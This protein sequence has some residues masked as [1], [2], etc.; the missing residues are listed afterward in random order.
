MYLG[1]YKTTSPTIQRTQ[2]SLKLQWVCTVHKVQVFCLDVAV[3]SFDLEKQ[4]SLNKRQMPLDLSRITN[5]NN[6]FLTGKYNV[7][8]IQVN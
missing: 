2:F 5:I 6:L 3:I 8:A 4:N 7:N 1:K